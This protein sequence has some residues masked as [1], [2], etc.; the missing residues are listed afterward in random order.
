MKFAHLADCHIGSWRDPKLRTIPTQAFIKAADLC[1][2]KNIDFILISGDLF[3]T[4]LP[5]LDS[6][7]ETTAKLKQLKDNNIPVY[8]I[9]GSHDFSPSGKTM[10]DVLEKAALVRNVVKGTAKDGKLYL[11]FNID[12]KTGAKIT[13]LLGR[14][15][16]LERSYYESLD[17]E[18]LEK[19]PGFK[20]FM[21]HTALTELKPKSLEKMDSSP[22]SFLPKGFNYYAAGHVHEIIDKEM[23]GFGRISYPGP[24]FPNTFAELE[25]LGNGGFY[26]VES[27]GKNINIEWQP[28]QVY[29]TFS[30]TIDCDHK[31]AKEAEELVYKEIRNKEF[32]NTIVTIRLTGVL[33]SGKI[34]DINFKDIFALCYSKSAYY[35]MKSTTMLK[36]KE[37]EDIK[38]SQGSAE[39]VEQ[40]LIEENLGKI[41]SLNLEREKEK[42]LII[43][44]MQSLNTEK[45][46]GETVPNFEERLKQD[47]EKLL[48]REKVLE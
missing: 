13:G 5:Y 25:K 23:P 9:P 20:I 45:S 42:S 19:E 4:S 6:L 24:L 31:T 39:E 30:I 33:E 36:S 2:E 11:N 16:M 40:R 22:L 26:F 37:F 10:I 21:L 44:L 32:N 14:K 38:I 8:I 48:E 7:K 28:I 29:N 41:T 12:E 43:S 46:E 17:K 3:N 35:V 15:G 34:S 47:I 1:I 27:D 18:S